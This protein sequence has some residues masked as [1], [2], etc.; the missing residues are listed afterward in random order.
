MSRKLHIVCL[1][2]PLPADTGGAR[3]MLERITALRNEGIKIHLY[4]FYKGTEN[5]PAELYSIADKVSVY[6]RRISLFRLLQGQPYIVACRSDKSL[7]DRLSE[8][9]AP[10]LFDGIHTT[11]HIH[12]LFQKDRKLIVRMHNDEVQ[13]Y[14][15]LSRFERNLLKRIYYWLES[16]RIHRWMKNLPPAELGCIQIREQDVIARSYNHL[17][18]F[19]LPPVLPA[20]V[21]SLIGNGGYCLYHGNLSVSENERAAIWLLRRVF[22][23]LKLPLVI[24]GK[25]P[26]SKLEKLVHFYQH[27]CLVADP[28]DRELRDLIQKAQINVLPSRTRTGIKLKIFDALQYGRHCIINQEMNESSPWTDS[29]TIVSSADEMGEAVTKLYSVPFTEAM[30]QNREEKLGAWRKQL[31]PI[32][33]LIKRLW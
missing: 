22:A 27:A 5:I 2:S 17:S 30:R 14:R 25:N 13:Y 29:C 15:E 32:A 23:R 18:T 3:D 33:T 31:D 8:D 6:R 1:R 7:L 4:C 9:S 19:L 16:K 21:E 26:S 11:A 10:I 12:A 28:S 24:A 20:R